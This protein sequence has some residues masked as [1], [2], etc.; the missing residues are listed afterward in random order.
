MEQLPGFDD[1][2]DR[3]RL[4][5]RCIYGLK[6]SGRQWYLRQSGFLK[7]LAFTFCPKDPC[8]FTKPGMTLFSDVDDLIV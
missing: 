6:Q 5:D 1:G 8:L 3:V 7:S 2:T 4:L